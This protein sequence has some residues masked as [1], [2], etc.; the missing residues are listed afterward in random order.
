MIVS[1]HG[2]K[3]IKERVGLP[4][5]AHLRHIE[6]VLKYGEQVSE[7]TSKKLNV[8]Y[9][10]FLYIFAFLEKEEPILITTY[11]ATTY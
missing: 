9:N 2:S 7:K 5:R 6:K 3:R 4:K 11:E 1:K 10:N 8:I